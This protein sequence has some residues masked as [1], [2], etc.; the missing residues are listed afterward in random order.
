MKSDLNGRYG[1]L[2]YLQFQPGRLKMD[3]KRRTLIVEDHRFLR[4][5]LRALL[6]SHQDFDIVGEAGDGLEAIELVGELKPDLVLL[7]MS[8]PRM[9]GMTALREIKKK[10]PKTLVLAFTIHKSPEYVF[11]TLIAGADGYILKETPW[12]DLIA[13]IENIL[14]GKQVISQDFLNQ[15]IKTTTEGYVT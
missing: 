2:A 1:Y 12:T 8:M 5:A 15:F 9:D 3:N 13:T 4:E 7:D 14:K 11:A 6:S 10:W